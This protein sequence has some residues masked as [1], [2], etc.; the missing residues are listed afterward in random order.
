MPG[1]ANRLELS[2]FF[3][4]TSVFVVMLVWTLD[5]FLNPAHASGV[6]GHFY[7][8]E[9]LGHAAMYAIGAAELVIIAAFVLGLFKIWSYGL[10]LAFHTVSTLSS[11]QQYLAPYDD[12][13][14]LFFAAWPMLAA[15]VALFLLRDSDTLLTVELK[16]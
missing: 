1:K 16:R 3:L 6:Y 15:C 8:I 5:K 14:T 7:G 12:A 9:G 4:R 13:N 10:V 2:L 11:Y